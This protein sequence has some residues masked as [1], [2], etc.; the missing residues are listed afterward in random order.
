MK[1]T[2][3]L[4]ILLLASVLGYS[5][6]YE[7]AVEAYNKGIELQQ[8]GDAANAILA[9]DLALRLKPDLIE[10]YNNRATLK[11][12]AGD[13]DGALA[14]LSRV[15]EISP[16]YAMSFYNRGNIHL[17]KSDYERAIDDFTNSLKILD[18][19]TTSYDK[20]AHA[21][22]YNNRGNAFMALGKNKEALADYRRAL[23]IIPNSFE[24]ITGLGSAKQQLGDHA[25]AVADYT[26]ALQMV[27][28]NILILTNR[29]GANEQVNKE[30]ALADYTKLIAL[31]P[32]DAHLHA[33]RGLVYLDLGRKKE[34]AADLRRAFLIDT[35]LKAEF[36]EFLKLALQ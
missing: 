19:M 24:A 7:K 22:S 36:G 14:D 21:M 17:S 31:D 27:P 11:L 20:R 34:A 5:Q 25:G 28:D 18:G 8:A 2:I 35:S 26:R 30:A 33:R 15:I 23:E 1:L 10:A 32:K 4:T 13:V 16:T 3:S 29:A 9:Y 12:N 6:N